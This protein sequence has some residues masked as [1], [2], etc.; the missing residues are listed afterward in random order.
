MK[1][2]AARDFEHNVVS[3]C[4]VLRGGGGVERAGGQRRKRGRSGVG[5]GEG[6][7]GAEGRGRGGEGCVK[8]RGEGG[9]GRARVR[10]H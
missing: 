3:N 6:V 4:M 7:K 8:V 2:L 9:W 10:R 5:R 1:R